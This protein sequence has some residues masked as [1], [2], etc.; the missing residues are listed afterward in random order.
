MA[1][2]GLLTVSLVAEARAG[3]VAAP[4]VIRSLLGGT[5]LFILL[6]TAPH[7]DVLAHLGGFVSGAAAGLVIARL[8]AR[9]TASGAADAGWAGAYLAATLAGFVAAL[10]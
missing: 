9:W 2:L 4:A 10:R 5:F 1:A 8:P 3:R 7:S 6:G